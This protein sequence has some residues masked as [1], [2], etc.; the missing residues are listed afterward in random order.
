MKN[1]AV[2]DLLRGGQQLTTLASPEREL[3][4]HKTHNKN[5]YK[6]LK[7]HILLLFCVQ[8]A[9]RPRGN[10][11]KRKRCEK[12]RRSSCAAG[13]DDFFTSFDAIKC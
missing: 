6:N 13:F 9:Q 7:I 11:K 12:Y 3:S 1:W 5:Y 10:T 8:V 2:V 4:T